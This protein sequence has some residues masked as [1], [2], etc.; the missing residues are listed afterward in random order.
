MNGQGLQIL[1]TKGYFHLQWIRP[2]TLIGFWLVRYRR[3]GR[4]TSCS[5]RSPPTR[6]HRGKLRSENGVWQSLINARRWK[7]R[8]NRIHISIRTKLQTNRLLN[9]ALVSN[10]SFRVGFLHLHPNPTIRICCDIRLYPNLFNR[11]PS[12]AQRPC[13]R[14]FSFRIRI[15]VQRYSLESL[16]QASNYRRCLV[17]CE[18]L[19]KADSWSGVKWEE[20]EGVRN[21][22]L[23]DSFIQEPVRIELFRCRGFESLAGLTKLSRIGTHHRDPKGPFVSALTRADSGSGCHLECRS[24]LPHRALAR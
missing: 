23:L 17:V 11:L 16:N 4:S 14:W 1:S 10:T 7:T 9:L 22:V 18:L 13:C 8:C 24:A 19:S 2:L 6:R 12:P 5:Y 3:L 21:E 15:H 20:N